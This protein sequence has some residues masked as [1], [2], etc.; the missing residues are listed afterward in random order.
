[1]VV[2]LDVG[3]V[4]TV[5]HEV[6][7][8][9]DELAAALEVVRAGRRRSAP[10]GSRSAGN[11]A[12]VARGRLRASRPGALGAAGPSGVSGPRPAG[13]AW[14]IAPFPARLPQDSN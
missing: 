9:A 2:L 11:R 6:V 14:P 10:Y 4:R 8:A 12:Q 13:L 3:R 5:S 1:M 7:I